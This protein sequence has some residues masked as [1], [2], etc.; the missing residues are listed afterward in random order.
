[1][2]YA[3]N[4]NCCEKLINDGKELII[5]TNVKHTHTHAHKCKKWKYIT[6]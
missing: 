1:M 2:E 6:T 4:G 5:F 3:I